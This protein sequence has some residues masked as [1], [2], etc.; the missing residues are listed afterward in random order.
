MDTEQIRGLNL[1]NR[2]IQTSAMGC[3]A[4]FE[5]WNFP[6]DQPDPVEAPQ[7]LRTAIRRLI[8]YN[9]DI[10]P[11][12][13]KI[14]FDAT[15]AGFGQRTRIVIDSENR[16]RLSIQH[17]KRFPSS[18]RSISWARVWLGYRVQRNTSIQAT[19]VAQSYTETESPAPERGI[20]CK[21]C[22]L[23]RDPQHK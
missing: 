13:I 7:V 16:D 21:V 1:I 2:G 5:A 12:E 8:V 20:T 23:L 15:Q 14:L 3:F 19:H 4:G 10:D 22:H 17:L 11:T 9:T 18:S 6:L